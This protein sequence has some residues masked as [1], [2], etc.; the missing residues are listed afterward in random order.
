MATVYGVNSTKYRAGTV[1]EKGGYSS[2]V[3]SITESY[4]ATSLADASIIYIGKPLPAN[5]KVELIVVKS[6]AF[7]TGRTLAIGDVASGTRYAAATSVASAATITAVGG[8]YVVGTATGDDQITLTCAGIL[9]SAT[10]I[11]VTVFYTL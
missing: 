8:N 3:L 4:T 5:A 10:A 1:A 9:N 2:Q 7:A 6:P 11:Q